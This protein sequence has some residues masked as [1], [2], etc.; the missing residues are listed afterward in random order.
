MGEVIVSMIYN[1]NNKSLEG[2]QLF[3]ETYLSYLNKILIFFYLFIID[4]IN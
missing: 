4:K 2:T 1:F 3:E